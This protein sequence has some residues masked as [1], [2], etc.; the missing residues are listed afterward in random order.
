[1]KLLT[2]KT[3]IIGGITAAISLNYF[4]NRAAISII[5]INKQDSTISYSVK[6]GFKTYSGTFKH[7][8][9]VTFSV[10]AQGKELLIYENEKSVFTI[11]IT[12]NGELLDVY[13]HRFNQYVDV[14]NFETINII[15]QIKN[16]V[17][18]SKC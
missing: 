1:M 4:Y 14:S 17:Y 12:K 6:M 16:N 2:K 18:E 10:K 8:S 15:N 7:N 9:Q 11:K 3:A 13:E 5:E